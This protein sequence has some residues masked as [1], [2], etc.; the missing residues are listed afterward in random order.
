MRFKIIYYA[1]PIDEK[2][3]PKSKADS[4]IPNNN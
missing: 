4:G 2:E 1:E 3:L